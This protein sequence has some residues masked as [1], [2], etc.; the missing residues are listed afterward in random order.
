M[1]SKF[2]AR[3]LVIVTVSV[4]FVFSFGKQL[5]TNRRL[6]KEKSQVEQQMKN[7]N[8][9]NVELTEEFKNS[10]SD[11]YIEQMARERLGMIKKGEKV[12]I[13]SKDK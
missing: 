9:K 1:K 5:I 11:S 13:D 6:N 8:Q 12:I 2:T 4:L 3:K 10:K 7:I